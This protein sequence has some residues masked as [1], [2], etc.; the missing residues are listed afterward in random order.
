MTT[1]T[2]TPP[3]ERPPKAFAVWF[4]E[5]RRWSVNS[6]Y[7][8]RWH[9]PAKDIAPLEKALERKSVAVNKKKVGLDNLQM[10]T[11]HFDGEM[12]PRDTNGKRTFKGKL[13]EAVAG[14]VL[15]SKIDVRNGAIGVVPPEMPKVAVSSEY[16]VYRVR[17]EVAL[18]EY[19]K[20]LFRTNAFRRQI[21][22]MISGASGRKRV[23]PSD[24]EEIDVPLPPLPVQ[25]AIVEHWNKAQ[26]AVAQA[27]A[28]AGEIAAGIAAHVYEALGTPAPDFSA[29][30]PK[31]LAIDWA[32]LSRWSFNYVARQKLGLLGFS[33]SK[34]PIRPMSDCLAGTMNGYCIRPVSRKTP[35]RMLKLNALTPA[36]LDVEQTKFVKVSQKVANRFCLHKGDV[37]ICRSVGSYE[38]VAKTA[39][40]E[41]DHPDILFPDIIIRAKFT[42][43]VLPEYAREIMETPLGRSFFQSN[44]RTAVGMW[45]IGAEDIRAFPI[46][47]PP[48][49]KQQAIVDMVQQSRAEIAAAR[50]Q[51]QQLAEQTKAEVEAMILGKRPAKGAGA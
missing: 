10:V 39:L 12:E 37:L 31:V 20:L 6:F 49:D 40:V 25:Q 4:G 15:Y 19:V 26:Q 2:A 11:L 28:R 43:D 7:R 46:P 24:L 18:P 14:D 47:V 48:K 33:Q 41:E 42:E 1:A 35:H 17:P 32:D 30:R 34:Y 36:G 44:A 38:Y 16:P 29:G 22:S 3:A 23:Q 27:K 13:F 9:W 45:K 5:L 21:N 51:A 50:E 8:V